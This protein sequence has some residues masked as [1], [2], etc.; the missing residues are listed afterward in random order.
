MLHARQY[1]TI[2]RFGMQARMNCK[3]SCFNRVILS[4]DQLKYVNN[5][6]MITLRTSLI[7]FCDIS[8]NQNQFIEPSMFKKIYQGALQEALTKHSSVDL[9]RCLLL[10]EMNRYGMAPVHLI[11]SLGNAVS[12]TKMIAILKT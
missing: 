8:S 6:N 5:E 2:H 9:I 7:Y 4:Y 12:L 11:A 3:F 10:N 1:T